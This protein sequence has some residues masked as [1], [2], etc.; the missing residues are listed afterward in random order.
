MKTK[1]ALLALLVAF[2]LPA[3]AQSMEPGEWEFTTTTTSPMM[4]RPQSATI[5]QCISPADAEDPTS[6]TGRNQT[7]ECQVTP[8]S[9]SSDSYNWTVS[10]PNQGMR[11]AGKAR[12][13]R[14]T[15][16]SEIQMSMDMQGQKME[17]QSRTTGRLLGPC[18]AK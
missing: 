18:K 1:N 14:G 7:A 13:G 6:F 15:I 16:E 8:G 3:A 9:R 2:S 10:C 12:F 17:M 4:P 11:G 5:T